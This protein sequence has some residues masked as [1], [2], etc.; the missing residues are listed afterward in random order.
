MDLIEALKEDD[1]E[2]LPVADD[3][4]V[5]VLGPSPYIFLACLR[6]SGVADLSLR[7]RCWAGLR[8]VRLGNS[9]LGEL[10]ADSE[11]KTNWLQ[12]R[13]SRMTGLSWE[14]R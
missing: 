9:I 14:S 1:D 5:V 2:E 7:Q 4:V 8:F 10:E 12:M 3:S 11:S 6:M 13:G